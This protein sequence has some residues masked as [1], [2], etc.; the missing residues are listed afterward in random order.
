MG[1]TIKCQRRTTSG[2][3]GSGLGTTI[4]Y[5]RR[6]TSGDAGNGLN[7]Y[8]GLLLCTFTSSAPHSPCFMRASY[9]NKQNITAEVRG[10]GVKCVC[11]WGPSWLVVFISVA[12]GL[13][14]SKDLFS[15]SNKGRGSM[16]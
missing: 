11:V 15:A 12:S 1:I 13:M 4:K 2:A 6:T 9:T 7:R 10:L 14:L 8:R 3:A 5:L 16:L